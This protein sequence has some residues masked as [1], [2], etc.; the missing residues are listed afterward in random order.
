MPRT[1][2]NGTRGWT[3]VAR[4]DERAG[5]S[6]R[7]QVAILFD[8]TDAVV[9]SVD[10]DDPTSGVDGDGGWVFESGRCGRDTVAR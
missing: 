2:E 10:D 1:S 3:A 6:N 5:S 7:R 8:S 9:A 4:S